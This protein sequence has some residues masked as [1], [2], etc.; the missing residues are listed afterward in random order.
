M[1]PKPELKFESTNPLCSQT[2]AIHQRYNLHMRYRYNILPTMSQ[3]SF[4][5]LTTSKI[6]IL[7]VTRTLKP[8]Q[9]VQS[10]GNNNALEHTVSRL[11]RNQEEIIASLQQFVG[12]KQDELKEKKIEV[13][14]NV[15]DLSSLPYEDQITLV[16]QSSIII[17]MVGSPIANSIYMSLGGN[18]VYSQ[19]IPSKLVCCGVIEIF[20]PL[21]ATSTIPVKGYG[22]MARKLGF[23]YERLELVSSNN[24]SAIA[25]TD[26]G[27]PVEIGSVV[28]ISPLLSS[29]EKML[30]NL[31]EQGD[32]CILPN[33]YQSPFL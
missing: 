5:E 9:L 7:L 26:S 28:P 4:A 23:Q 1:Q 13:A 22:Q 24:T 18:I 30:Q 20:P 29:I 3:A 31:I 8:G 16:S 10:G 27:K 12:K 25:D 6:S 14:L 21:P 19:D 17:G 2:S 33:V 32:S 11:F 15:V